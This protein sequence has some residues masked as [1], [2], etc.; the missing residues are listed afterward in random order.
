MSMFSDIAWTEN[1]NYTACFRILNWYEITQRDFRW[2]T[3]LS[4]V[5][6]QKKWYGTQHDAPE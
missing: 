4:S 3:G 2:D 1:G 5:L 6:V